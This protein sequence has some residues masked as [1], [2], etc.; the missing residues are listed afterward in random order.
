[1]GSWKEFTS[2]IFFLFF[3]SLL[4]L[5]T[6]S[7]IHRPQDK[8][9]PH[10]TTHL[11][12]SLQLIFNYNFCLDIYRCLNNIQVLLKIFFRCLDISNIRRYFFEDILQIPK[13]FSRL[14]I[15]ISTHP[16][17]LIPDRIQTQKYFSCHQQIRPNRCRCSQSRYFSPPE[18]I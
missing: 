12:F 7:C 17:N 1:M 10:I 14:Q 15:N 3:A 2:G 11:H 13:Y 4:Q 16:V 8:H 6:W 9:S 18:R 5:E